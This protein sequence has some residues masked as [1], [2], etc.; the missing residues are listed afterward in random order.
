MHSREDANL[1][2]SHVLQHLFIEKESSMMSFANEYTDRILGQS[3]APTE[4]AKKELTQLLNDYCSDKL[5]NDFVLK[6][7]D[8]SITSE[9]LKRT[10]QD[11][12]SF[13]LISSCAARSV[14][15]TICK[16]TKTLAIRRYIA[17]LCI[18]LAEVFD[19]AVEVFGKTTLYAKAFPQYFI[20][21]LESVVSKLSTTELESELAILSVRRPAIVSFICQHDDSVE[22]RICNLKYINIVVDISGATNFDTIYSAIISRHADL[23][24]QNCAGVNLDNNFNNAVH[25]Y[26]F[27]APH[28]DSL[29]ATLSLRTAQPVKSHSTF[30]GGASPLADSDVVSVFAG[31]YSL[32]PSAYPLAARIDPNIISNFATFNQLSQ[33]EKLRTARYLADNRDRFNNI[34]A[35]AT[36]IITNGLNERLGARFNDVLNRVESSKFKTFN[37]RSMTGG[38]TSSVTNSTKAFLNKLKSSFNNANIKSFA[39]ATSFISHQYI[40]MLQQFVSKASLEHGTAETNEVLSKYATSS[41]LNLVGAANN[42]HSPSTVVTKFVEKPVVQYVEKI[43]PMRGGGKDEPATKLHEAEHNKTGTDSYIN[44]LIKGLADFNTAY[45]AIYKQLTTSINKI[46]ALPVI[47]AQQTL[48]VLSLCESLS[49]IGISDAKTAAKISGF[50]QQTN[51]QP[52]YLSYVDAVIVQLKGLGLNCF[53]DLGNV[54]QQLK[55]LLETT[56]QRIESIRT[57]YISTPRTIGEQV[58][59]KSSELNQP[60]PL[61]DKDIYSLATA[62]KRLKNLAETATNAQSQMKDI[63][64]AMTNYNNTME[65]RRKCI[66]DH[67]EYLILG[68]RAEFNRGTDF[69]SDVK[70]RLDQKIALIEQTRDCMLYLNDVVD[71]ALAKQRNEL[72]KKVNLSDEQLKNIEQAFTHYKNAQSETQFE[73]QI[74]KLKEALKERHVGNVYRIIK[75]IKKV[76]NASKY[77]DFIEQLCRELGLFT[78]DF[79]WKKF[80]ERMCMLIALSTVRIGKKLNISVIN[81]TIPLYNITGTVD[82]LIGLIITQLKATGNTGD[83]ELRAMRDGIAKTLSEG[84]EREAIENH[85][86]EGFKLSD[87]LGHIEIK[88]TADENAKLQQSNIFKVNADKNG[89]EVHQ[90]PN[91]IAYEGAKNDLEKLGIT[92]DMCKSNNQTYTIT[93]KYEVTSKYEKDQY[94][95]GIT[96]KQDYEYNLVMKSFETIFAYVVGIFDKYFAVRYEGSLGLPIQIGKMFGGNI[97]DEEKI[98]GAGLFDHTKFGSFYKDGIIVEAVPFYLSAIH[99]IRQYINNYLPEEENK[100]K[101]EDITTR[102]TIGKFSILYPFFEI[103]KEQGVTIS[104]LTIEQLRKLIAPLN[105]IWSKTSGTPAAKLSHALDILFSECNACMIFTNQVTLDLIKATQDI[106]KATLDVIGKGMDT[107][108]ASINDNLN[109]Q[110]TRFEGSETA[111][112]SAYE[113]YV[114]DAYETIKAKPAEQHFAVL[115]QLLAPAEDLTHNSLHEYFKFMELII[116]PMLTAVESYT[117]IFNLYE[118]YSIKRTKSDDVIDF[119]KI[120]INDPATDKPLKMWELI[121]NIR[122]KGVEGAEY[123]GLFMGNPVVIDYNR[124]L[125]RDALQTAH[126]TGKFTMPRF[127]IVMDENTYPTESVRTFNVKAETHINDN[128][129]LLRQIYPNVHANTLAD[130]LRQTLSEYKADYE[131]FINIFLAYPGLS[132]YTIN[133]IAHIAKE[134]FKRST[135]KIEGT[136]ASLTTK[137]EQVKVPRAIDRYISPPPPAFVAFLP[138]MNGTDFV[139]EIVVTEEALTRMDDSLD[140]NKP[141]ELHIPNVHIADTAMYVRSRSAKKAHIN[142]CEYNWLDWVIYTLAR[143]DMTNFCVPYRLVQLLQNRPIFAQL[144]LAPGVNRKLNVMHYNRNVAGE[145]TNILTQNIIARS[146]SDRNKAFVDYYQMNPQWLASLVSIIPYVIST[147]MT[148]RDMMDQSVTYKRINV[149]QLL[150]YL[151]EDLTAFF[152]ELSDYAP[153]CEFMT[154]RVI[155]ANDTKVKATGEKSLNEMNAHPFAQLVQFINKFNINRGDIAE[156]VKLEWAN[157]FAFA[158]IPKI[159]F[160]DYSKRDR[161]EFIKTF[162]ADKIHSGGIGATFDNLIQTLA[163]LSWSAVIAD[164]GKEIAEYKNTWKE[165]DETIIKVMH[166]MCEVDPAITQQFI[167]NII[168]LYNNPAIEQPF[169]GGA[170]DWIE[171]EI[172]PK[173]EKYVQILCKG[174]IGARG[175]EPL[176]VLNIEDVDTPEKAKKF[177]ELCIG[178][179]KGSVKY[180]DIGFAIS[181]L[182]ANHV[183]KLSGGANHDPKDGR[184]DRGEFDNKA[185]SVVDK[186]NNDLFNLFVNPTNLT[187]IMKDGYNYDENKPNAAIAGILVNIIYKY[188]TL[189]FDATKAYNNNKDQ[190]ANAPKAAES[191]VG[192]QPMA[193]QYVFSNTGYDTAYMD[194]DGGNETT[195]QSDLKRMVKA[196]KTILAKVQ[197]STADVRDGNNDKVDPGKCDKTKTMALLNAVYEIFKSRFTNPFIIDSRYKVLT[198]DTK[199]LFEIVKATA[200]D[201]DLFKALIGAE[202]TLGFSGGVVSKVIDEDIKGLI[203]VVAHSIMRNA[204]NRTLYMNSVNELGTKQDGTIAIVPNTEGIVIC[205]KDITTLADVSTLAIVLMRLRPNELAN[206]NETMLNNREYAISMLGDK[207]ITPVSTKVATLNAEAAMIK[208]NGKDTTYSVF[209]PAD[210]KESMCKVLIDLVKLVKDA[211]ILRTDT[212]LDKLVGIEQAAK[213]KYNV[214]P[215]HIKAIL[216]AIAASSIETTTSDSGGTNNAYHGG[217]DDAEGIWFASGKD[218]DFSGYVSKLYKEEDATTE[219]GIYIDDEVLTNEV[220]TKWLLTTKYVMNPASNA[221]IEDKSAT[222]AAQPI[223]TYNERFEN[224]IIKPSNIS[225]TIPLTIF[226]HVPYSEVVEKFLVSPRYDVYLSTFDN[227]G[228]TQG[229]TPTIIYNAP[230]LHIG[231]N[232]YKTGE[233]LND[234]NVVIE[235]IHNIDGNKAMCHKD[236]TTTWKTSIGLIEGVVGKYS[237]MNLPIESF[238]REEVFKP[239]LDIIDAKSTELVKKNKDIGFI[240]KLCGGAGVSFGSNLRSYVK[241]DNAMLGTTYDQVLYNAYGDDIASNTDNKSL[242]RL[243]FG[244]R[245]KCGS[246]TDSKSIMNATIR[247]FRKNTMSSASMYNTVTFPSIIYGAA[248]LKH[249]M[250]KLKD[251]VAKVGEIDEESNVFKFNIKHIKNI[252]EG[253]KFAHELARVNYYTSSDDYTKKIKTYGQHEDLNTVINVATRTIGPSLCGNMYMTF[254][255]ELTKEGVPIIN[256]PIGGT[257]RELDL[258][259]TYAFEIHELLLKTSYWSHDVKRYNTYADVA[260]RE[261]FSIDIDIKK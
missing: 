174:L 202:K 144:V 64:V 19:K 37:A 194:K 125:I 168:D 148:Y 114:H 88:T 220:L 138:Q 230:M 152:N 197:A 124:L 216:K 252:C 91:D 163:R 203:N 258:L 193:L 250:T 87:L 117:K 120:T 182:L 34:I 43:V 185:K 184:E 179:G 241:V 198:V 21:H 36:T 49:N 33:T 253:N 121:E 226:K 188:I 159:T 24:I 164:S 104:A 228:N 217:V 149:Y 215:D 95:V 213:D 238:I 92:E 200:N 127:W 50:N 1:D 225:I 242:Y 112:N 214:L 113:R 142:E 60:C 231:I 22:E 130:Y 224:V 146:I 72:A 229:K 227:P 53:N 32:V 9:L 235:E 129:A 110:S 79:D 4:E 93:A 151:I 221:L 80:S 126:E 109:E 139:E 171:K 105:D 136:V 58:I 59:A 63:E 170:I 261:P 166:T 81:G 233:T 45:A 260:P 259:S 243:I 16:H 134:S 196:I 27:I 65:Q 204:N 94:V 167:N 61:T 15:T 177:L 101:P 209:T 111:S 51:L 5:F 135:A 195:V 178:G 133:Q 212:T 66:K 18:P 102:M 192:K 116:T 157:M 12:A 161:F 83:N 191:D 210:V 2:S 154:D 47:S 74:K 69:S 183:A 211:K 181:A 98:L 187:D 7:F 82:D 234:I 38:S 232:A 41:S 35:N 131:Q 62:I 141:L 31:N 249:E 3:F 39:D 17:F 158:N 44:S 84:D 236:G 169:A 256:S 25:I 85:A 86:G 123:K 75:K 13:P 176:R 20:D 153:Y 222:Q 128:I 251:V 223:Y 201:S 99:I 26:S 173:F 28:W 137:L 115:K 48:E 46:G 219:K 246:L 52:L 14:L 247:Y 239:I 78:N 118:S 208:E 67:Y 71:P 175:T 6:F 180:Q 70:F 108:V 145:Y 189:L 29:S 68:T 42:L 205:K 11:T 119:N 107:V 90:I 248:L 132:D 257:M 140:A 54:L 207:I 245:N 172:Q 165:L 122:K 103:F 89:F 30:T 155:A 23:H 162:A 156:I 106:S 97:E 73:K 147:L 100:P 206:Y 160:P 10:I 218:G 55:Q 77:I 240:R 56:K 199:N 143:C 255:N 244:D 96:N 186:T 8:A 76:I 237:S 150:S 254:N 57:K 40:P 190:G